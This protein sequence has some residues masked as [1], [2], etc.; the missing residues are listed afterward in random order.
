MFLRECPAGSRL[1]VLFKPEGQLVRPERNHDI[2]L[3]RS[4]E[5]RAYRR[6]AVVRGEA[7]GDVR[8]PADV[9]SGGIAQTLKNVDTSHGDRHG[10]SNRNLCATFEL[11]F[12]VGFGWMR[13]TTRIFRDRLAFA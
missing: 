2:E 3:P 11:V 1:Q 4:V 13:I 6:T 5:S 9:M 7:L 12:R 8:R 10:G